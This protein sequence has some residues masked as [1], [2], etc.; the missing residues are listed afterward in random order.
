ML[1][2]LRLQYRA[3]HLGKKVREYKQS[4]NTNGTFIQDPLG[5]LPLG[6]HLFTEHWS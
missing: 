2:P 1:S 3:Q 4:W 6:I 5:K